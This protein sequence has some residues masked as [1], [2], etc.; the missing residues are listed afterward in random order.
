MA[1]RHPDQ[2]GRYVIGIECDGAMY[3]SSRVARDRDRLRQ[4]VLEGLGWNLHRIWGTSWYRQREV[5]KARLREVIQAAIDGRQPARTKETA[6]PPVITSTTIVQVEE[7]VGAQWTHFYVP[8]TNPLRPRL[9]FNGSNIEPELVELVRAIV[10]DTAPVHPDT[11]VDTIKRV[12]RVER[13]GAQRRDKV[14]AAI[15]RLEGRRDIVKDRFGFYWMAGEQEVIV[16]IP[17]PDNEL[18][19]RTAPLVSPDEIK[20]AMFHLVKDARSMTVA[21][22]R[23]KITRLFGWKRTGVDIDA[24]LTKAF[25]ELV[26]AGSLLVIS[27]KGDEA[28][29]RG[30]DGDLPD[31]S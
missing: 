15:T 18:T 28:L 29:V 26:K 13:M 6:P 31:L 10:R 21:E 19:V 22:L 7:E 3:H 2:P 4:D 17:T 20:L 9:D 30:W 11:I 23:V 12:G 1:V 16:R 25:K 5:E 24:L 27:G 14:E 8:F